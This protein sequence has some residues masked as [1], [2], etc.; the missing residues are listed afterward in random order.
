MPAFHSAREAKDFLVAQIAQQ[1]KRENVSLSEVERKMLYFTESYESL[2][3]MMEVAEKFG[4]DYDRDEYEAKIAG[5]IAGATDRFKKE[6]REEQKTWDD[7]VKYLRKED[8]YILVM[9]DQGRVLGPSD[10]GAGPRKTD[11][12]D[13]LK[14]LAAGIAVAAGLVTSIFL[15][16]NSGGTDRWTPKWFGDLSDDT[17][18]KIV[19]GGIVVIVVISSLYDYFFRWLARRKFRLK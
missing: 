18:G 10:G 6:S 1:A 17:R 7:A 4:A 9:V 13:Q 2:P 11:W 3:D 12:R 15:F 8:H 5:L 16:E 19:V 14:L